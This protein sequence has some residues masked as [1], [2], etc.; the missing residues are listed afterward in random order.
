VLDSILTFDNVIEPGIH[1][2]NKWQAPALE[3]ISDYIVTKKN[4]EDLILF[5]QPGL[6]TEETK[7]LILESLKSLNV[8]KPFIKPLYSKW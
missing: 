7:E 8:D 3:S 4:L 5:N 2:S 1:I 6:A